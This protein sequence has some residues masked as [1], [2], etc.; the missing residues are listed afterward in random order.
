MNPPARPPATRPG[1]LH[2]SPRLDGGLAVLLLATTLLSCNLTDPD[3]EN[4][5][6]RFPLPSGC[7]LSVDLDPD[8]VQLEEG[9]ETFV[10]VTVGRN[11]LNGPV[12]LFV[13]DLP[14]GITATFI[15][16][17]VP[18]D[19][20]GSTLSLVNVGAEQGE[21]VITVLGEMPNPGSTAHSGSDSLQIVVGPGQGEACHPWTEVQNVPSAGPYHDVDFVDNDLGFVGSHDLLRSTDGGRT[22]ALHNA[23]FLPSSFFFSDVSFPTASFGFLRS[24]SADGNDQYFRTRDGGSTWD[25]LPA[26]PGGQTTH[27]LLF[28]NESLGFTLSEVAS[29]IWRTADGGDTWTNIPVPPIGPLLAITATPD[30]RLF[31]AG[32]QSAGGGLLYSNDDGLTW[33]RATA[34]NTAY[35]WVDFFDEQNGLAGGA[36][37]PARTT[38]GGLTWQ[39]AV[40]PN[41]S[42]MHA[43]SVLP[44]G[45][46]G[47]AVGTGIWQTSDRG[48]SWQVV[49]VDIHP[50]FNAVEVSPG[51]VGVVVGD[52]G[53]FR[54]D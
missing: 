28:V 54:R 41:G 46:I 15:T 9:E 44:G 43:G 11:L 27:D 17:P 49:C 48:V 34:P 47:Y 40:P 16:D 14:D 31:I 18:T 3:P 8:T 12:N 51:G 33:Q 37:A 32:G 23:P 1:R 52:D 19:L 36:S 6:T 2:W 13:R 26:F 21:Y 29:S 5:C 25:F 39:A 35:R 45:F 7:F 38:D 10:T 53:I 50:P 22:W 42:V 24:T 30:G 20:N 4:D